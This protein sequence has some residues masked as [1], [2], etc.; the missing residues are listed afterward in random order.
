MSTNQSWSLDKPFTESYSSDITLLSAWLRGQQPAESST[1]PCPRNYST[2]TFLNRLST[3]LTTGNEHSPSADNVHAISGYMDANSIHFLIFSENAGPKYN[4]QRAISGHID[5]ALERKSNAKNIHARADEQYPNDPAIT[6]AQQE[7]QNIPIGPKA[8]I[9]P[10]GRWASPI[11]NHPGVSDPSDGYTDKESGHILLKTWSADDDLPF[12]AHL[13]HVFDIL[14]YL[15]SISGSE[16][17]GKLLAPLQ[18]FIHRRA[19]R[20]LGSRVLLF[21]THWDRMPFGVLAEN[22][23]YISSDPDLSKTFELTLP[24]AAHE[25]V[26]VF[27]QATANV[28]GSKLRYT[29]DLNTVNL[30]RWTA[31]FRYL[32]DEI[33]LCL[34]EKN[35]K[36]QWRVRFS[37]VSIETVIK[38]LFSLRSSEFI[39]REAEA[40]TMEART[41]AKQDHLLKSF[42]CDRTFSAY[43]FPSSLNVVNDSEQGPDLGGLHLFSELGGQE[44]LPQLDLEGQEEFY[45]EMTDSDTPVERVMHSLGM[46]WAWYLAV[47]SLFKKSRL[48]LSGKA[49]ELTR[50]QYKPFR[51]FDYNSQDLRER[52][53]PA[54]FPDIT[55][56]EEATKELIQGTW[57]AKVH[58]EASLMGFASSTIQVFS[59]HL[60]SQS[61]LSKTAV[62]ISKKCCRLCWL[63]KEHLNAEYPDLN[64]VLPG[65][66]GIFYPW[67][68]PPG[69]PDAILKSLR[70]ELVKAIRTVIKTSLTAPDSR[71]SSDDDFD[72]DVIENSTEQKGL[73]QKLHCSIVGIDE[74]SGR[75][76]GASERLPPFIVPEQDDDSVTV[77]SRDNGRLSAIGSSARNRGPSPLPD[78]SSELSGEA[79]WD[80]LSRSTRRTQLD[81]NTRSARQNQDPF[82]DSNGEP[83]PNS[84]FDRLRQEDDAARPNYDLS[85][86]DQRRTEWITEQKKR[87]KQLQGVLP[88]SSASDELS[89]LEEEDQVGDLSL[90]RAPT[91]K[92][93]YMYGSGASQSQVAGFEDREIEIDPSID[94]GINGKP[95]PTSRHLD[96]VA[97][98]RQKHAVANLPHLHC[99]EPSLDTAIPAEIFRQEDLTCCSGCGRELEFI[100]YVCEI[101]GEK[102]PGSHLSSPTSSNKGKGRDPLPQFIYPPTAHQTNIYSSSM[103]PSFSS[104]SNTF[105]ASH[106]ISKPRPLPPE[107][108]MS[109][110]LTTLLPPSVPLKKTET[111]FEL[112]PFCVE[113]LG[114]I[115]ALES[116]STNEPGL[117]PTASNFSS[118]SLGDAAAQRRRAAPKEKGQLRHVYIERSWGHRGWDDSIPMRKQKFALPVASKHRLITRCIS[119]RH[120]PRYQLCRACYSQVHEIHPSHA[121][122][123][124]RGKL[125]RSLSDSEL[126]TYSD[127]LNTPEEQSNVHLG[128]KCIKEIVGVCFHCAECENVDIC[129]ECEL[130]G[131]PGN[132]D[133]ADGGH[134]YAHISI[135]IPFP[136][137]SYKIQPVSRKARTLWSNRVGHSKAASEISSYA[138]TVIGIGNMHTSEPISEDHGIACN[139]SESDINVRTVLLPS[140]DIT[141]APPARRCRRPVDQP[142]TSNTPMIPELYEPGPSSIA[143]NIGNPADY[144][145][146][147]HPG[148]FCDLCV[149]EIQGAWFRSLKSRV[150]MQALKKLL[151]DMESPSP[152]INYQ[153]Y[154]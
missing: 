30:A 34:L 18:H 145:S 23:S 24:P 92:L 19:F 81:L 61:H 83:S 139:I 73:Y 107:P 66:H 53:L 87:A 114:Y 142:I 5:R 67:I 137:P 130:A 144:L 136:L 147:T 65:T 140:R 26:E 79:S 116:Q 22:I 91:G 55:W 46:V 105:V 146:I 134:V 95:R 74:Y 149:T 88:A 1:Q 141:H 57:T 120:C 131:L 56:T 154:L 104:S 28:A 32:W 44:E 125:P 39:I 80:T 31:L 29:Y 153:I 69:I 90:Q 6:L 60:H 68:P 111:G 40:G 89:L 59:H 11:L 97:T 49:V 93:Y 76:G 101:C 99:S 122:L 7:T 54:V 150:N 123:V 112:C 102:E 94:G 20:K 82:A 96:W 126:L 15:S 43:R 10:G 85:L 71:Q 21:S 135:K 16:E 51:A 119:A 113:E 121:F 108:S 70:D 27:V 9:P 35:S 25:T 3:L 63:L 17:K 98:Q 12:D 2:L 109:T 47:V 36:D 117:S 106:S 13:Q 132:I 103:S 78:R 38:H 37:T 115:H 77:S 41:R 42:H 127:F 33:E 75:N 86:S 110:S 72:L 64:L 52:I 133:S 148:V 58:A 8:H 50:V 151:V 4:A 143:Y 124:L 84:V 14:S 129:L 100:K 118:S 152:I 138:R 48:D 62:G 45:E 128:I